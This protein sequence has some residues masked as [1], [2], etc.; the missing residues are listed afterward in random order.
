M[1]RLW[2]TGGVVTPKTNTVADT[3]SN[4]QAK[5]VTNLTVLQ[6]Q[7]KGTSNT[8]TFIKSDWLHVSTL[9]GSSS[10]LPFESSH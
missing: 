7:I 8:L 2:L 10:G 5:G 1:M 4:H 3:Y 6:L 9:T